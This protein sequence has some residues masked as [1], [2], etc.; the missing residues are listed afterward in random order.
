MMVKRN[1]NG[2]DTTKFN[3]LYIYIYIYIF[4]QGATY[5]SIFLFMIKKFNQLS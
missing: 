2:L 1:Y 4:V 3:L 5:N